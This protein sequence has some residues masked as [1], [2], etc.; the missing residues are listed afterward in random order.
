MSIS[1]QQ[2]LLHHHPAHRPPLSRH[3]RATAAACW[4]AAPRS[5]PSPDSI[6]ADI[7][8]DKLF[9]AGG[10]GS[11]RGFVYQSA[12]PRDAF[13]NPLGGASVVEGS[14]EFRQRFGKSWGAVAFVDAGSA[15]PDAMP[16]FSL[17]APRVGAGVGRALL[18]RLRAGAARCRLPAQRA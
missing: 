16:D 4:P 17:F 18:H 15:Y 8:P 10:G 1:P 9:Y 12:G 14:V 2:R 5:A 6:G 11:V 7:P 13:N 3:Q